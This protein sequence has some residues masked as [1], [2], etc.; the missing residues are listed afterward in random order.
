M[1]INEMNE[2]FMHFINLEKCIIYHILN[3]YFI[4]FSDIMI[5]YIS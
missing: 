2:Y 5:L 3:A 1:N 4:Y